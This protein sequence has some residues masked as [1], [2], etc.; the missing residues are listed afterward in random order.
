MTTFTIAFMLFLIMDP[1]G[2]VSTFLSMVKEIPRTKQRWIVVR[3]MLI[4]LAAMLLFNQIGEHIFSI[5]N[6]SEVAIYLSSGLILFIVAIK[7]LFPT[8]DSPRANLPKGEPFIIPLAIPLIAGPSL[9]A[10]IMLYA[11]QVP[12]Y[13]MMV[14]AI[15]FAWLAASFVLLI[16]PYLKR[17]LGLN[18]LLAC[19]R[20]MGMILIL[21]AIQRFAEGIQLFV[22]SLSA[23]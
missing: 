12:S 7:I 8:I 6:I 23:T 11:H 5:L 16:A 19:E 1:V 13:S 22:K 3:E 4:A 9:L 17:A 21:L 15:V 18:G 2:N 10:T 14:S 20:L